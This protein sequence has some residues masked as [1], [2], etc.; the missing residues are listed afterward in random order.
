MT[1]KK[2]KIEGALRLL[3]DAAKETKEDIS[4]MVREKYHHLEKSIASI[5]PNVRRHVEE[6]SEKT[7][8]ALSDG[9]KIA[10]E[11][12]ENVDKSVHEKPWTYVGAAAAIGL[13]FGFLLGRK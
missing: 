6:V 2:E 3:D 11:T 8:E 5:E 7:K 12:A 13:A 1:Q 10:L 9:K 4:G